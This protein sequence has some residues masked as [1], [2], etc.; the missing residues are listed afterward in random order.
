VA[1]ILAQVNGTQRRAFANYGRH[2][3]TAFQLIDDVLDYR[4][5]PDERGKNLGDDLT[6]GKPTL[7]LIHALQK[8]NGEQRKLIRLAIEQGGLAELAQSPAIEAGCPEYTT[9]S[10]ESG[11]RGP[12]G[13]R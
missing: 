9:R 1:A 12:G 7:P 4:G 3:G 6:E 13:A 10:R 2:V 8:G 11:R 5:S